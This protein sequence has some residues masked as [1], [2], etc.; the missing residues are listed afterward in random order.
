[1]LTVDHLFAKIGHEWHRLTQLSAELASP[2]LYE[3]KPCL[4]CTNPALGSPTRD[5]GELHGQIEVFKI[6]EQGRA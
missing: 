5:D 6:I 1:V 3:S 2:T 4:N